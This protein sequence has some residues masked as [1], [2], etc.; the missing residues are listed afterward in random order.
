VLRVVQESPQ[1]QTLKFLRGRDSAQ[2][3][4][5]G[6]DVYKLD[7]ASADSTPAPGARSDDDERRPRGLL[8]QSSL[9]P[10]PVLTQMESVVAEHHDDGAF[11][12]VQFSQ[13]LHQPSNLGIQERY[14]SIIG[15]ER[16]L[17][18]RIGESARERPGDQGRGRG[19]RLVI[20]G[21]LRDRNPLGIIEVE[22]PFRGNPGN[23][24]F[25]QPDCQEE[26]ETAVLLH[27]ANR[28]QHRLPVGLVVIVAIGRLNQRASLTRGS[29][30]PICFQWG[31]RCVPNRVP[32]QGIIQSVV[33]D[34]AHTGGEVAVLP[35]ELGK[36]DHVGKGLPHPDPVIGHLS[37]IGAKPGEEGNP[38]RVAERILAHR[39][40]KADA[41]RSETIQVRGLGH[42]IAVAMDPRVQVIYGDEQNVEGTSLPEG[43]NPFHGPHGGHCE[44]ADAP[45][46]I[47]PGPG[48]AFRG[49]GDRRWSLQECHTRPLLTRAGD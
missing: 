48:G 40:V 25:P 32:R 42:R 37:G 31:E 14:A 34:L 33:E 38:A 15:V 22:I 5:G 39:A 27:E 1:T 3:G 2:I 43:G 11:Q 23:V 35:E 29:F 45:K 24:R 7:D 12:Q 36:C 17:L 20:R 16:L 28:F 26:R 47:A 4:N 46:E 18:L 9:P 8:K 19:V 21:R 30:L 10:Q 44:G 49:G 13:T 41:K 6:I